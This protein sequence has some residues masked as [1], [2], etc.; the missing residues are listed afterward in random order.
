MR[1][2][3]AGI[4]SLSL[5]SVAFAEP[6]T[7]VAGSFITDI[8]PPR[9]GSFSFIGEDGSTF[10]GSWRV[11]G[12]IAAALCAPCPPGSLI[13]PGAHFFTNDVPFPGAAGPFPIGTATIGGVTYPPAGV[14]FLTFN[15]D[16]NFSGGG[17]S[18]P[19]D[20]PSEF[21]LFTLNLP[22][23][24]TGVLNGYDIFRLDPLLLFS[25]ELQGIGTAHVSFAGTASNQFNYLRTEYEFEPIPEPGTLTMI[26]IGAGAACSRRRL[27]KRP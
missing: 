7:I 5:A 27:F 19:A 24:F 22:F 6:V 15:G 18:L 12:S 26:L 25:S 13:T 1:C 9:A 4:L 20:P 11:P 16:L 10:Q 2:L 14:P 17:G 23:S 8:Q 3:L 21:Q